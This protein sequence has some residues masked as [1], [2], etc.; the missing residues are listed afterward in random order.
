MRLSRRHL[1]AGAAA[2]LLAA[3]PAQAEKPPIPDR[4]TAVRVR[5]FP[6]DTFEPRDKAKSRFNMVQ[7]R[8]GL[9]LQSD[10]KGFGGIS[11]LR[12]DRSGEK[13]TAITDAGLWLTARTT[14]ENG[15]LTGLTDATMAAIL[16][17]GG[18]P[19]AT[20]G[21]WDAEALAMDSNT[22]W[23]A[24]ERTN[25]IYRFPFARDGIMAEG[26]PIAVPDGIKTLR[27]NRGIEAMGLFPRSS[28]FAGRLLAIAE[29]AVIA[30]EDTPAFILGPE[31]IKFQVRRTND[32]DIT[33]LDFLPDGSLLVLERWFTPMRGLGMRVRRIDPVTIK[34][35]ATVDGPIVV[36]GDLGFQIDNME[37]LSVWQ[38]ASGETM[39]SIISDDNF[40]LF[41]RTLLLDFAYKP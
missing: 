30:G 9:E 39:L 1:L 14:R 27:F 11:G 22:A 20:T 41:Q 34:P 23:I 3:R 32:F 12:L 38:N 26:Q 37:G 25:R 4:P 24:T 8:G 40:S 31:P 35:G 28:P 36:S 16:G 2:P 15:R 29:R 33:D 19:L 6:I 13:L 7:F 21:D 10:F 17:P 18:K 5:S